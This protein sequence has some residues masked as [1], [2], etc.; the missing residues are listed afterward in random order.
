MVTRIKVSIGIYG[1]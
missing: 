1:N